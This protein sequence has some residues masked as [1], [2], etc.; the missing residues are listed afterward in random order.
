MQQA[1][2]IIAAPA[3]LSQSTDPAVFTDL[4]NAETNLCVWQRHLPAQVAQYSKFVLEQQPHATEIRLSSDLKSLEHELC[5]RLPDHVLRQAFIDDVIILADMVTCLL[6]AKAVGLRL[7]TASSAT[8]PR[9]HVDKLGCRLITTYC[10][11]ATEW[12]DNSVIDRGKL[13]RGAEGK[14]DRESG[15]YLNASSIRKLNTG[16]VALLKGE[17]W[18]G[19]EGHGIVHR[20][21]E[22]IAPQRRLFLTMDAIT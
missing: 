19:N 17:D 10:G 16:D 18:P 2:E 14:A 11:P 3:G 1:A 20:S 12:L 21:P 5:K 15:L 4:Y 6:G 8:C 13:G 9:F 7:C 22:L